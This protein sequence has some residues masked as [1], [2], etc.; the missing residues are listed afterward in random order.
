MGC[1]IEYLLRGK[2]EV[3]EQRSRLQN[4]LRAILHLMEFRNMPNNNS[5][6]FANISIM[7]SEI[8]IAGCVPKVVKKSEAAEAVPLIARMCTRRCNVPE[9]LR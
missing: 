6:I 1:G 2:T 5:R 7:F 4:D 9:G 3:F 8:F